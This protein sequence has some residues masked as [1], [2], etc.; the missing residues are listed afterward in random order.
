MCTTVCPNARHAGTFV[1]VT[2]SGSATEEAFALQA[3]YSKHPEMPSFG[4]PGTGDHDFHVWKMVIESIFFMDD[5]GGPVPLTPEEYY[6]AVP[7][8]ALRAGV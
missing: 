6:A 4:K 1:D 7:R 2:A 5:Y 8:H 3:L